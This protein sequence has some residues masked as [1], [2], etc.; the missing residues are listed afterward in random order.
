MRARLMQMDSSLSP[1]HTLVKIIPFPAASYGFGCTMGIHIRFYYSILQLVPERLF[2]NHLAG[3]IPL[4]ECSVRA[5]TII[6]SRCIVRCK[7]RIG[8]LLREE[9]YQRRRILDY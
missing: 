2:V 8:P 6:P 9:E 4:P 5:E 1:N 7:S 3:R